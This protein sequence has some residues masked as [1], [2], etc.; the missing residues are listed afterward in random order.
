MWFRG[1]QPE[2]SV[3]KRFRSAADG[4]TFAK[5]PDY[6]VAHAVANGERIVELFLA[7]LEHLPPAVDLSV[8]DAR[9]G[10]AWKGERVALPDVREALSRI[11][12]L[13]ATSGGVEVA[14]YTS[15]DQ[16]TLNPVLE[17]F[18]Y[19]RTDQWLYILKGKGLEE[20]RLVRTNSWR[21]RRH[22]YP[23]APELEAALDTLVSALGLA[24]A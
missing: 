20:R 9:T 15:E 14:V 6:Y 11:K 18:V 24:P 16:L 7:L 21:L 1:K 3:W 17:L 5:E 8:S 22:E 12:T 10:R 19:A 23:P 2:T 13:L 4:F